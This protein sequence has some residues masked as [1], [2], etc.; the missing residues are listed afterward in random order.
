MYNDDLLSE[1]AARNLQLLTAIKELNSKLKMV[2]SNQRAILMQVGAV[3]PTSDDILEA[4]IIPLTS[5]ERP[6]QLEKNLLDPVERLLVSCVLETVCQRL[7]CRSH[8]C[9]PMMTSH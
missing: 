5:T 8:P 1:L 2:S 6:D 7:V 3:E 9:V 4:I